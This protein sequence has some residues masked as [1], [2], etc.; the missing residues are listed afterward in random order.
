MMISAAMPSMVFL[1]FRSRE[2]I[3]DSSAILDDASHQVEFSSKQASK[4]VA[5]QCTASHS[6][7]LISFSAI[8]SGTLSCPDFRDEYKNFRFCAEAGS[9]VPAPAFCYAR[10]RQPRISALI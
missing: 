6:D 2:T 10:H 8:W 1:C 5:C 3:A 7:F 9:L 4:Q